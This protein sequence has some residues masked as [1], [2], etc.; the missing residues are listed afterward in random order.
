MF[1]KM[2][3]NLEESGSRHS[4]DR[5][6]PRAGPPRTMGALLDLFTPT[7]HT[8][9]CSHLRFSRDEIIK[10]VGFVLAAHREVLAEAP[11]RTHP[12]LRP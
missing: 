7:A 10:T 9:M 4:P 12:P 5:S 6:G 1:E 2:S 8:I 11:V 3:G